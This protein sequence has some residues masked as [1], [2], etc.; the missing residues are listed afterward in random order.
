MPRSRM[1]ERLAIARERETRYLMSFDINRVNRW[2]L[3]L[4]SVFIALNFLD[5]F[6]TLVALRAQGFVELNP[7]ASGLFN[8]D[9]RGFVLA[10]VLKYTPVVPL[11]YATLVGA[12][13]RHT[14]PIRVVKVSVFI[15]LVA[16]DIFYLGVVG[17]NTLTL[18]LYYP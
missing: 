7:I 1:K 15:V 12:E 18:A 13:G 8:L 16:A 3:I 5:A 17:S 10:L 6:T 4:L 14:L 11:A 9:F 2:L